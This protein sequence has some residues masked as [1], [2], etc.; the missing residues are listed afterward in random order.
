[1]SAAMWAPSG[2]QPWDAALDR[3]ERGLDR[4]EARGGA[5]LADAVAGLEPL[6][7][8]GGDLP[9]RLPE[10]LPERLVDRARGL[11]A[12]TD[13]LAHRVAGELSRTDRAL[14]DLTHRLP[15]HPR[16]PDHHRHP[17]YLDTRA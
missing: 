4:I 2:G 5:E 16:A 13:A 3:L 10:P 8:F 6:P 9:E 15:D 17:A 7:T 14:R 12:R 11:L 1:M